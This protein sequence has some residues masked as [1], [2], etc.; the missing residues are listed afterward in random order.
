MAG[1]LGLLV[2]VFQTVPGEE[3][4][5]RMIG[6]RKHHPTSFL[7]DFSS[8]VEVKGYTWPETVLRKEMGWTGLQH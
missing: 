5:D 4:G 8:D 1:Q 7:R 6:V 2:W 3:R